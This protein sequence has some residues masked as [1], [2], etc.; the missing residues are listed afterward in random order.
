MKKIFLL[1]VVFSAFSFQLFSQK[2]LIKAERFRN[3]AIEISPYGGA[4]CYGD[5]NSDLSKQFLLGINKLKFN[6]TQYFCSAGFKQSLLPHFGYKFML[7]YAQ[8]CGSDQDTYLEGRALYFRSKVFEASLL[9]KYIIFGDI[10]DRSNIH[11]SI[12]LFAGAGYMNINSEGNYRASDIHK[13]HTS[14]PA[15]PA[16]IGYEWKINSDFSIGAE[17]TG[18]YLFTDYLDGI[19]TIYSK[20]KDLLGSLS[21]NISYNLIKGNY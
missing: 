4:F 17:L 15:V 2:G 9:C 7:S 5:I 1:L 21:I 11:H 20:N 10:F 3:G 19:S 16:G 13:P 12:Y 6:E 18:Q 8:I 14:T